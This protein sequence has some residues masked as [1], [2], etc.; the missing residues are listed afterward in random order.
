ML[1]CDDDEAPSKT[2]ERTKPERPI[3]FRWAALVVGVV[4]R[5][6]CCERLTLLDFDIDA[7]W[8][9]EPHQRVDGLI[10]GL[11]D[12]DEPIVRSKLKVLHGLLVNVRAADNAETANIG[13]KGN[14]AADS[15]TRALSSFNDFLR[16]LIDHSVIIGTQANTNFNHVWV[17]YTCQP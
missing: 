15:S 3:E 6:T 4:A 11:K 5:T 10:G 13:G 2:L 1:L 14:R 8:Q 12:I 9:V 17:T 16:R 7:A